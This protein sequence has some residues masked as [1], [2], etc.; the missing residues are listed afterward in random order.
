MNLAIKF[1]LFLKN[2]FAKKHPCARYVYAITGG[3][4]LGE[5]FTLMEKNKSSRE[6]IFLSLPDMHHRTVS[7]EKFKFGI[8]NKI[9]DIVKRIPK[10]VYN[11]CK[12]QY[13]ANLKAVKTSS[14][15]SIGKM[16]GSGKP[17]E[18]NK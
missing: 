15:V 9:I 4:F 16:M 11:T 5:M 18:K 1:K 14:S 6:Y 2:F 8:D 17:A 13:A 12:K 7:Y 3:V 10:D